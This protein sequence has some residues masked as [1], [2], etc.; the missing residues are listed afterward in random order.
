MKGVGNGLNLSRNEG[1][2]FDSVG[3]GLRLI[4]GIYGV[5]SNTVYNGLS[6]LSGPVCLQALNAIEVMIID[7]KT[8]NAMTNKINSGAGAFNFNSYP[9]CLSETNRFYFN[10][11]NSQSRNNAR[12]LFDKIPPG[13]MIVIMN[14]TSLGTSPSYIDTWKSDTSL[15]GKNNSLYHKLHSLG[16]S[17][18][19]SFYKKHRLASIVIESC[20]SD[21]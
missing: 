20:A 14:W 21:G 12:L 15:Y 1:F 9:S 19:D 16:L 3:N 18:I 6:V 10:Y 7:L 13:N 17:K 11:N 4:S 8:G 5:S 2:Q